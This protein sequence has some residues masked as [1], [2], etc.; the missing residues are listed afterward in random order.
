MRLQPAQ[1]LQQLHQLQQVQV[2]ERNVACH[3]GATVIPTHTLCIV[4]YCIVFWLPKGLYVDSKQANGVPA[5]V[6]G[7]L[8]TF[9]VEMAD[10]PAVTLLYRSTARVLLLR[11]YGFL[12]RPLVC[13]VVQGDLHQRDD[14]IEVC[15]NL[16]PTT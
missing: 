12:C 16:M 9:A 8:D 7:V 4:L 6:F 14:A 15:D 10:L 11:P 5:G 1:K 2:L 13:K 3:M